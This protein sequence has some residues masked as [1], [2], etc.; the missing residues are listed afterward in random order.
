MLI[1]NFQTF[2]FTG[3]MSKMSRSEAKKIIENE[4]GKVLGSVSKKLNFLVSG[5]SKP[6]V[7]KVNQAKELGI[8]IISESDWYNL[9]N[10]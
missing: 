9:I 2:M 1:I 6:T 7:K 8:T 3:G 10:F 4:G 5:E